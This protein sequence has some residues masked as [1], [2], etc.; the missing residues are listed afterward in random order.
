MSTRHAVVRTPT[1]GALTLV[2]AGSSLG[3]V[4]FPGH[5]TK[6][7]WAAFGPKVH[8]GSDPVLSE[9]SSQ[10]QEYLAGERTVFD[11]ITA[12]EGGAFEARVSALLR[13]IPFGETTTYGELAESLG[14]RALARRV[15]QAVGRNPLSIVVAC[16]RVVGKDGALRGYAGGL[17]RKQAL[18]DLERRGSGSRRDDRTSPSWLPRLFESPPEAVRALAA[19]VHQIRAA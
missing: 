19:P 17:A 16:H 5:W 18:L 4:Y 15:G 13:E 6:P 8:A 11:L 14:G 3:G 9:A 1:L 10:L 7:D 2:A 12:A